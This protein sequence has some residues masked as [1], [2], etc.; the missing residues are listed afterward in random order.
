MVEIEKYF[1]ELAQDLHVFSLATKKWTKLWDGLWDPVSYGELNVEAKSNRPPSRT[2]AC[3]NY[4]PRD[5]SLYLFSGDSTPGASS[6][7]HVNDLWRFSLKTNRWAWLAGSDKLNQKGSETWPGARFFAS[8]ISW[9]DGEKFR[10]LYVGGRIPVSFI[11]SAGELWNVNI[12]DSPILTSNTT[13]NSTT[14]LPTNETEKDVVMIAAVSTASAVIAIA[15][16]FVFLY[17]KK[18]KPISGYMKQIS[19]KNVFDFTSHKSSTK[20]YDKSSTKDVDRTKSHMEHT[21]DLRTTVAASGTLI[22]LHNNKS[23]YLF[24]RSFNAW[25]S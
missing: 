1:V 21:T 5:D 14:A 13:H 6:M 3:L 16:V 22:F 4:N 24:S 8:T 17:L 15:M 7:D 19:E 23:I 10:M 25:V 20:D 12:V 2:Y 11:E 9:I 18:R